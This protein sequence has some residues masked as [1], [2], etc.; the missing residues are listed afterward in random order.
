MDLSGDLDNSR[1]EK[2][3]LAS[4][5]NEK[6]T[7]PPAKSAR[8]ESPSAASS[9]DGSNA[10]GKQP[11]VRPT[12]PHGKPRT[13]CAMSECWTLLSARCQLHNLM[14]DRCVKCK[15]LFP[16][17]P[18]CGSL[19]CKHDLQKNHCKDPACGGGG[20][21]C[22]C[23]KQKNTCRT[24]NGSAFCPH[25]KRTGTCKHP[26][27]GSGSALCPCGNYR[28]ACIQCN[29]KAACVTCMSVLAKSK[30]YRPHCARCWFTLHPEKKCPRQHLTKEIYMRE[31][32][33]TA[34]PSVMYTFNRTVPGGTS[35]RMPDV[36]MCL[37]LHAVIL[38]CNENQHKR[39][40]CELR[41]MMEL[42]RDL[43][44]RPLVMIDFNPDSYTT[45]GVK[46]AGCFSTTPVD[47]KLQVNV[48]EWNRRFAILLPIL[49]D[50]L[51]I[52]PTREV[53]HHVLFYD[54]Y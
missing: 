10:T 44:S 21:V 54:G 19:L 35:R 5:R 43:G 28:N 53:T 36:L 25:H 27:C 2:R 11:Y 52:M 48:T 26:G 24:C 4:T 3:P 13:R 46:H 20:S 37:L 16:Q 14:R 49:R 32:L 29:T 38:E 6:S 42:F 33:Q 45:N 9:S 40:A 7:L 12:C 34:L 23:G 41:R 1:N 31:A 17:D 50:A 22:K 51:D 47:G 18:R 8:N 39:Y 30:Q 15:Y